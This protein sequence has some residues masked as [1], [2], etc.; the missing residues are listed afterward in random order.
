M[1]RRRSSRAAA[2]AA[3]AA[4]GAGA[5]VAVVGGTKSAGSGRTTPAAIACVNPSDDESVHPREVSRQQRRRCGSFCPR[6]TCICFVPPLTVDY[7]CASDDIRAARVSL[8]QAKLQK[9]ADEEA[10]TRVLLR[11]KQQ[12]VSEEESVPASLRPTDELDVQLLL[13]HLPKTLMK[14]DLFIV[15]RCAKISKLRSALPSC[16]GGDRRTQPC[17]INGILLSGKDSA[18]S[19]NKT[20]GTLS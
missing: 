9:K 17:H 11:R 13:Q 1:R 4:G 15:C 10:E 5:A 2:A 8:Q 12:A 6:S 19:K 14:S 3:A 18:A 16:S 7:V 20:P